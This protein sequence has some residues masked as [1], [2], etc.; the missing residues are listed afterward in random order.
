ME[1][2]ADVNLRG[3]F[4]YNTALEVAA[5]WGY[6]AVVEL[7]LEKA[8]MSKH[9]PI[10]MEMFSRLPVGRV[11]WMLYGYCWRKVLMSMHNRLLSRLPVERVTPQLLLESDAGGGK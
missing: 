5:L 10:V 2:G 3:G 7:L 4:G 8:L 1:A 11:T 6:K 9:K